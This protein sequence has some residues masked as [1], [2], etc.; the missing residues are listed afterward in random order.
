MVAPKLDKPVLPLR[1]LKATYGDLASGKVFDVTKKL[2]AAVSKSTLRIAATNGE[3]GGD[4]VYGVAKALVVSYQYG[5]V[6]KTV[7]LRENETLS[8][9]DLPEEGTPPSYQI[10][11]N[12]LLVW[13]NGFFPL[14]WSDGKRAMVSINDIPEP[15]TVGGPWQI[16]FTSTYDP[17]RTVTYNQLKSWTEDAAFDT[18]YFSGT[19]TY[20]KGLVIPKALLASG[21]RLYLDLGDVRDLCRIRLNG[22]P[23][24]TLWKA[25]FR[26]DITGFARVGKNALEVDVTNL[27]TNRLIGDEQFP[28]DMGWNGAQLSGWPAWFVNHTPRPEPRRKT[29]TT[30]RHNYKDT[31]LLPSGLLGP[32]TLRPVRVI[33]LPRKRG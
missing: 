1:I 25:P 14:S 22:K 11:S 16:K 33:P 27:W 2:A 32:V 28:D 18:K 7:T 4:P 19:G 21:D 24:A 3:M 31:A 5:D 13:V 29:F 20:S 15:Q 26:V 17:P 6:T 8:I 23:V 9:G 30:W 10:V 12:R